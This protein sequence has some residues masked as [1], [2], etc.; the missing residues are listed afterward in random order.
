MTIL[1]LWLILSLCSALVLARMAH[2]APVDDEGVW[3]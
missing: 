1:T 2:N 3:G